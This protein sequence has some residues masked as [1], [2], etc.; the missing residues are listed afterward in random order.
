[1]FKD[2]NEFDQKRKALEMNKLM[3]K[4]ALKKQGGAELL[5]PTTPYSQFQAGDA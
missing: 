2:I 3:L 4:F 5:P 1:M